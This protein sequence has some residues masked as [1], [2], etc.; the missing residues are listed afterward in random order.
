MYNSYSRRSSDV[1]GRYLWL[2]LVAVTVMLVIGQIVAHS[3]SEN[4]AINAAEAM[5]YE[6]IQVTGPHTILPNLQGCSSSDLVKFDVT[7]VDARGKTR[8]FFVCDGLFKGATP[9]FK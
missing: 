8:T 3:I 7:G 2:C 6:D 1:D 5:R 4:G 9:R